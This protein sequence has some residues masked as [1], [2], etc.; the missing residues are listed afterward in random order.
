MEMDSRGCKFDFTGIRTDRRS[1]IKQAGQTQTKFDGAEGQH[2][3][4]QSMKQDKFD[5]GAMCD[6]DF[7]EQDNPSSTYSASLQLASQ[8]HRLQHFCALPPQCVL[9]NGFD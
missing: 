5:G 9:S 7:T 1:K 6:T 8:K 3:T 4:P 2:V